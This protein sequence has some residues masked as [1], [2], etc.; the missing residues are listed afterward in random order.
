MPAPPLL[1]PSVSL[2]QPSTNAPATLA[3][4]N[5]RAKNPHLS[6]EPPAEMVK[7]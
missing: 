6:A 3:Q 1:A 4:M 2:C 5:Y 7:E